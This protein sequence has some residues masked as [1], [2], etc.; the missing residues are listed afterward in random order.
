M[1]RTPC[2]VEPTSMGGPTLALSSVMRL[3]PGVAIS[4]MARFLL[5]PCVDQTTSACGRWLT[6]AGEG[7]TGGSDAKNKAAVSRR[8][9]GQPVATARAEGRARTAGKERDHAGRAQ[10]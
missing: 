8:S 9:G 2:G 7:H 6:C 3:N 10:G 4:L 1:R 5:A